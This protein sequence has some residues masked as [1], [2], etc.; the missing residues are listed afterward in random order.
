MSY[1]R[2]DFEVR[3]L[4]SKHWKICCSTG[5]G[6]VYLHSDGRIFACCPEYWPTR[7]HAEKILDRYYP[8]PKHVWEHGDV[9]MNTAGVGMV[10]I[11]IYAEPLRVYC[12]GPCT[13]HDFEETTIYLETGKFLFNIKDKL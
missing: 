12:I 7:I 9:F 6:P 4:H 2:E 13:G 5:L 11:R 3:S 1:K 10:C 8:K